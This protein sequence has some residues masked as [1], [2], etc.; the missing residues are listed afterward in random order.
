MARIINPTLA[1]L[2]LGFVVGATGRS[3]PTAM[4]GEIATPP[5]PARI[6]SPPLATPLRTAFSSPTH[7]M[8]QVVSLVMAGD[9]M[10]GRY[11]SRIIARRGTAY[12]FAPVR[13][14]LAVADVAF[15]NLE[16]PLTTAEKVAQGHDLRAG[17]PAAQAL[18]EAGFD[19]VSLANNHCSDCGEEGL[20]ETMAALQGD[21]TLAQLASQYDVHVNQIQ[22]WR[23]QL[24]QNMV[25]LF[26]SGIDKHKDHDAEVKLLQAKIGQL[27][28]ENDFLA[29]VL[30]P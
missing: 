27:T 29:T 25:S 8:G 19:V 22:T 6:P 30:K 1:F 3:L 20:L 24:K 15:A 2:V 7:K 23:N 12:P 28:M 11:V 4:V 18:A 13:D 9:V 5:V 17:P 14:M 21:K 16:S 26:D 10:L